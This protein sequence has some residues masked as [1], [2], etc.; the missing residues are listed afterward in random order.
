MNDID[1]AKQLLTVND[2]Q[3]ILSLGRTKVFSLISS[4]EL[5]SVL[6]GSS[7]RIP[8]KSLDEFLEKISEQSI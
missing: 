2:V 5:G 6:I 3:Q 1:N 8:A 7:R 4:G